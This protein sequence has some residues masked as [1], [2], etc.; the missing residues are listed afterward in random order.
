[1]GLE[2][3]MQDLINQQKQLTV[4]ALQQPGGAGQMQFHPAAA[5]SKTHKLKPMTDSESSDDDDDLSSGSGL[6]GTDTSGIDTSSMSQSLQSS[7][8]G[9]AFIKQ[10]KAAAVMHNG[11]SMPR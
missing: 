8:A 3:R 5:S 9:K 11:N 1:M 6:T 10:A 4:N 7:A 2:G